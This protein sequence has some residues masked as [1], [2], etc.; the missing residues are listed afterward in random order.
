MMLIL[1]TP[2]G[3]IRWNLF[4]HEGVQEALYS[5]VER[6]EQEDNSRDLRY[7]VVINGE[8]QVWEV[9]C[10]QTTCIARRLSE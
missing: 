6:I 1:G 3:A 7:S 4:F 8:Q 5:N 2:Q 10:L 9:I